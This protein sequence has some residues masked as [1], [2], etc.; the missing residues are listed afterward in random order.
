MPWWAWLL[1]AWFALNLG[2]VL[3]K[4]RNSKPLDHIGFYDED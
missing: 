1:L 2:F 3:L 4:T